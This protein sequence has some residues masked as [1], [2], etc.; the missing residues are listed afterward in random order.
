MLHWAV[1]MKLKFNS[2]S[3]LY[4]AIEFFRHFISFYNDRGADKHKKNPLHQIFFQ[5]EEE[6][7]MHSGCI[8]QSEIMRRNFDPLQQ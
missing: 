4:L 1:A 8:F 2:Y 6:D 5:E 7:D 3:Y